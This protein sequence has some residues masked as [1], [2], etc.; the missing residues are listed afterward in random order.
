[1]TLTLVLGIQPSPSDGIRVSTYDDTHYLDGE[2]DLDRPIPIPLW[3][4]KVPGERTGKIGKE[5]WRCN[6]KEKSQP[7][8]LR[9]ITVPTIY[10]Y[11]VKDSDAAVVIAPGGGYNILVIDKEGSDIAAWLNSIG[12]SAFVLKY[13]VP[14]RPWLPFGAAALMDAQRAMGLVRHMAGGN[15]KDVPNLNASKIGFM[16][17]SAGGHLTGHIN[18]AWANRTYMEVDKADQEPC[19]PDFSIMVYPWRSVSQPPVNEPISGASALNVTNQTPPTMLIQTE[20]DHVHVENSI[21]YYL[22]LKQ[23]GAAPSELHVYPHGDHGYGRCTMEDAAIHKHE[24]CSWPERAQ[25]FLTTLGVIVK[26]EEA[27]GE[28]ISSSQ[29]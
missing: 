28:Q 19:R 29:Q 6:H 27:A 8:I 16:G 23:K 15:S 10:P 25:A 7:C 9:N 26:E 17:F 5:N 3:P 22:A 13:R 2:I 4:Q 1:M 11:L 20:D 18:V 24:V 21:F 12:I 14:G